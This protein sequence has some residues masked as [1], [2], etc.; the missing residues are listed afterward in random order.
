MKRKILLTSLLLVFLVGAGIACYNLLS[1]WLEY[2]MGEKTYER[3]QSYVALPADARDDANESP[4][5]AHGREGADESTPAAQETLSD[6]A[7]SPEPAMEAV[8]YPEVDFA[9]LLEVN[10]DVVGWVYIEDTK[11]NYPI[12]QGE[13]N[14]YYVSTLIDGRVNGAGSIFM[15]YHNTPDFS[16]RHTILY[17]HNMKNGTMFAGITNYCSQEYYD[18]HPMGLIMTPE[19]NYRFE[20]VSAYV[21]SLGDPAW[22][23][24][25]VD[26]ADAMNWLEKAME[27]S[28]FIS[29]YDPRP[30][31]RIVTLS[32][33]TYEFNDARFV[34]VG[35]LLGE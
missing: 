7:G 26:D 20:I 3:M 8:L 9:S 12:L 31:D 18:A 25:F 34:L 29:R 30:D 22:Q 28:P 17:G 21:A 33:C 19:G 23:L 10:S 14:R 5:I 2:R 6:E 1:I 24:E 15:D 32:T 27:R 35:V 11:I 13:D 4:S 16:D